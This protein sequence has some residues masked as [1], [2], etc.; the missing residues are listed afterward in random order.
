MVL[1]GEKNGVA[2]QRAAAISAPPQR[3]HGDLLNYYQPG[4]LYVGFLGGR[5]DKKQGRAS[6]DKQKHTQKKQKCPTQFKVVE[7]E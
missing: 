1:Q 4:G 5:E 3:S 6:V 2:P 7:I